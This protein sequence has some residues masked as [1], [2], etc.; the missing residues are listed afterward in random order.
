MSR[1]CDC[2]FA[3]NNNSECKDLART[4]A[5]SLVGLSLYQKVRLFGERTAQCVL[6]SRYFRRDQFAIN[7]LPNTVIHHHS[8]TTRTMTNQLHSLFGL[9]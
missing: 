9:P 1:Q 5:T 2:D 8:G 4:A 6:G 7:F 3:A